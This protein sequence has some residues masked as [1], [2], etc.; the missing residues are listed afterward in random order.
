[1]DPLITKQIQGVLENNIFNKIIA[2]NLNIPNPIL[3]SYNFK[4]SRGW[5]CRYC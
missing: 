4:G 1:M 2:L 5:G 3:K